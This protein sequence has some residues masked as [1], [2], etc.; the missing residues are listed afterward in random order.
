MNSEHVDT[1]GHDWGGDLAAYALGALDAHETETFEA[2]LVGCARCRD[3]LVAFQEVV[4][5]L[6]ASVPA[7]PA[8]K[9]L[10]SELMAAVAAEPKGAAAKA[11]RAQPRPRRRA[12]PWAGLS[13]RLGP[14]M[15]AA[16]AVVVVV[17]GALTLGGGS[18]HTRVITAQVIGSPGT[19]QVRLTAGHAELVVRHFAAPP[20]GRVYEIW[21]QRSAGKP[22]PA[23]ALLSVTR[24]GEGDVAVPGRLQGVKQM[25]VTSEPGGGSRVPTEAPV[26]RA[27]LS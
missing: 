23:G 6:P 20:A 24:H 5:A 18:A 12:W 7:Y 8:P 17:A 25:M 10:R 22:V 14:A 9:N 27:V 4:D 11:V 1:D 2:H 26:I 3:E 13:P 21:L 15:A 19:A 16:A